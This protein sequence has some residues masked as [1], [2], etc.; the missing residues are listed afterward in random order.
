[1]SNPD[2]IPDDQFSYADDYIEMTDLYVVFY[3]TFLDI[4]DTETNPES[5]ADAVTEQQPITW[6]H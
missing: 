5:L 6:T 1:M 4:N 2:M 3:L